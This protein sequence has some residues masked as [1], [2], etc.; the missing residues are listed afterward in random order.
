MLMLFDYDYARVGDACAN[1]PDF[2]H[3]DCF[4]SF[5][6]DIAAVTLG[7]PAEA[8]QMCHSYVDEPINKVSCI[9]GAVQA[10]FWETAKASEA[11]SMC[12]M[13]ADQA[14]KSGCYWMIIV[15]AKELYPT[16]PG[17]DAFRAQVEQAYRPWCYQ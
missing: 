8:I 12:Q 7:E 2:A 10:R 1:A 15:R 5:G 13:L 16:R 11:L 6:R 4:E 17:Y 9:Q 3:H 14:E